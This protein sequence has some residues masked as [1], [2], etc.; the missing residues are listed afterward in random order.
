M[1][2]ITEKKNSIIAFLKI[3]GPALPVRI[4]REIKMEP[5]FASAIL[6]ELLNEKRIVLSNL[7]IGASPLYLI[8]GQENQLENFTEHLKSAEKEAFLKLKEEKIL[9]DEEQGPSIRVSLRNL[10]DFAKPFKSNEKIMWKYAF[11]TKEEIE[12]ITPA[13]KEEKEEGNS[14]IKVETEKIEKE[15]TNTPQKKDHSKKEEKMESI[16]EESSIDFLEE[17]KKFLKKNNLE[18]I[19]EIQIS[20]REIVAKIRMK[21]SLG[22]FYL[23]LIA[24][25]KKSI[26]KEEIKS[27]IQR[28]TYSKMPCLYIIRKSPPK[29]IENFIKEYENICKIKVLE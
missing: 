3:H 20:K 23:I 16:F 18:F 5:V 6:S 12:E 10:K 28:A 4:A 2:D 14:K 8:S 13:E 24:K 25:D 9:H 26:S 21:T 22:N 27:A 19:E 1:I 29:S 7:K 11:E 15:K 17:V